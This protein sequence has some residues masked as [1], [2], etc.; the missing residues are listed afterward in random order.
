VFSS[1]VYSGEVAQ[2]NIYRG[3]VSGGPYTLIGNTASPVYSDNTAVNG[4]TYYYKVTTVI[5]KNAGTEESPIGLSTEVSATP[6]PGINIQN[7][8]FTPN[9]ANPALN[10][11]SF[12][13]YNA[14]NAAVELY[15]YKPNGRLVAALTSG[16]TT[17]TWG[18][19]MS[20]IYWDGKNGSGG[21]VEGGVYVFQIKV[22]GNFMGKGTVVLAK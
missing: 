17:V 14:L 5:V 1:S 11:V 12:S 20:Q 10:K 9:S 16:N 21:V 15:I 18:G 6:H 22:G 19:K 13:V 8:P 3:T 4:T 7:N 2:Y